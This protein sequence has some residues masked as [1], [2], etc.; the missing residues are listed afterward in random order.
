MTPELFV[1]QLRAALG[2]RLRSVIVYGSASAG[3]FIA[4]ASNIDLLVVIEPLGFAELDALMPAVAAWAKS[5]QPAPQLFSPAQLSASTDTFAIELS[6]MQ[7]SR[8]VLF[9]ADLLADVKIER[10]DLRLQVE[11]ELKGK[12]LSLRR[13][14]VLTA[15]RPDAVIGLMVGSL[16]SFLVLAR[17]TLRLFEDNVPLQKPAAL[18]RLQ[19]HLA[20]DAKP[21]SQ[22]A[23]IKQRRSTP[24]D[25]HPAELFA[26]YLKAIE[27]IVVGVD[28]LSLSTR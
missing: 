22:I 8:K 3:D 9:G 24:V 2:V 18:Q 5:G 7:K 1:E 16:S 21:F 23:E 11:R 17:A 28:Q 10:H 6:D 4:G 26:A 12:L 14:Y 13:K 27:A 15:G 25:L 20:F 19:T